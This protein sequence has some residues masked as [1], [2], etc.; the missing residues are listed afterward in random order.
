M[1]FV[2][3]CRSEVNPQITPDMRDRMEG[4]TT[5]L[6]RIVADRR[7]TASTEMDRFTRLNGYLKAID[8]KCCSGAAVVVNRIRLRA[9]LQGL[10]STSSSSNSSSLSTPI[11][12]EASDFSTLNTF[13]LD[14][15]I[16]DLRAM[17]SLF[18]DSSKVV[19]LYCRRLEDTSKCG[20]Q[21]APVV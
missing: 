18:E 13:Q 1:K 21:A 14:S 8:D 11:I 16:A 7:T 17:Y 4:F 15:L 20:G 19:F 9:V 2:S 6:A 3:G 10:Q 12:A 5:E